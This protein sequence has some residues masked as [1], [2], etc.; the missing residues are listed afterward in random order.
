MQGK[1]RA[2]YRA[3]KEKGERTSYK[4]VLTVILLATN[5]K[6][7]VTLFIQDEFHRKENTSSG[8]DKA[9]SHINIQVF[10]IQPDLTGSL[11]LK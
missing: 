5:I 11:G 10:G 3:V 2:R 7:D 9:L 1:Y 4:L 6:L 8:R